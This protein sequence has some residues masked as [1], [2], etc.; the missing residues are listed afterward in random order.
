MTRTY[1]IRD[2][3]TKETLTIVKA[4]NS[5]QA[6]SKIGKLID[7]GKSDINP[8]SIDVNFLK[9]QDTFYCTAACYACRRCY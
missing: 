4:N 9:A 7:T 1:K 3:L 8:L 2:F 6:W 5:D